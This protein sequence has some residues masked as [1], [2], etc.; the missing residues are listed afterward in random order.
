MKAQI[1]EAAQP[2]AQSTTESRRGAILGWTLSMLLAVILVA[3]FLP[4]ALMLW[5]LWAPPAL[6]EATTLPAATTRSAATVRVV[7]VQQQVQATAIPAPAVQADP[8]APLP[9]P[10]E[11]VPTAYVPPAEPI[12]QPPPDA[13]YGAT[14]QDY[15]DRSPCSY[16]RANPQTCGQSV[17]AIPWPEGREP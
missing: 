14:I 5:G 7:P 6:V 4:E 10:V 16:P 3:R 9:V 11:V 2:Q 1:E 17:P 13:R 8:A 15:A 12:V